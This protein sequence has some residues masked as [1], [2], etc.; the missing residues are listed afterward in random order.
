MLPL[1]LLLCLQLIHRDKK[2]IRISF[3]LI[4]LIIVLLYL[5]IYSIERILDVSVRSSPILTNMLSISFIKNLNM[6]SKGP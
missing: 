1:L 5:L 2:K 3:I 6:I 4:F